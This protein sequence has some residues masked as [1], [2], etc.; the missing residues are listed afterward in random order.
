MLPKILLGVGLFATLF[1]V[2]IFSGKI[3]IGKKVDGPKGEV[4]VWG[5]LPDAEMAP[6]IQAFNPKVKT[7]TV[8]YRSVPEANF[9]QVLLESLANGQ[10]PDA[11]LVP[12]QIILSQ[13]DR[14]YTFPTT[15]K[16]YRDVYVDGASIFS[17]TNGTLA[18]PITVEPMVLFYNRTLFS[19]HGIISPPTS[20]DELV[21]I[22]PAL[23]VRQGGQ[24]LES[25]IAL[26]SPTVPYTKDILMA[27]VTQ[28]GQTPVLRLVNQSNEIYY[29]VQANE[30]IGPKGDVF[31]LAA[32]ARYI[33]QFADSG[34]STYTWS[35]SQSSDPSDLFVGEKLAMYIGY[36]GEYQRL[37]ARNP[38]GD[39]QMT[40]FPQTKNY[41][42]YTMGMRM[43]AI[44]TLK[45]TKNPN[46]T[47]AAQSQLSGIETASQIAAINGGVPALRSYAAT[48]LLDPVIARSMLVAKGW[49]DRYPKESSAYTYTMISDIINFRYGV[50][51]AVSLF[52]ARMRDLYSKK[53]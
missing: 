33:T 31:P 14:I 37:R 15:E 43:Y 3:N 42:S 34:Q 20:W 16:N 44:A 5:T 32:T 8:R 29:S 4:Q 41:N 22:V 1:S 36:S 19:K 11:I 10:G 7:Y 35:Q 21:S 48:P 2:L 25:A 9:E 49:Y 40:S 50:S 26:G 38:R 13:A 53:Y 46:A 28:L 47:F 39:F 24:F 30:A 51:D 52:V 27:M 12:H 45:S 17:T 23:T 18:I 6:I